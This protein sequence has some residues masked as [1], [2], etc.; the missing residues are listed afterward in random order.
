LAI[1]TNFSR[2]HSPLALINPPPDLDPGILQR[3]GAEVRPIL[4][5]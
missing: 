2:R 1:F 4:A 5:R 3:F